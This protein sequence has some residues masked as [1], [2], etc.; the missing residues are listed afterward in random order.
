MNTNTTSGD[1]YIFS[2]N[3]FASVAKNAWDVLIPAIKPKKI[4]E[5]GSYEGASASYLI[6]NCS[7]F[8]EIEIHC[9][10][11]WEGGEEH[12]NGSVNMGSV[13]IRFLH[14]TQLALANQKDRQDKFEVNLITHK[15]YSSTCLSK[16]I[17][18]TNGNYFDFIYIDGSHQAPDVLSDAILSFHLLKVGGVI[19]FDDYLWGIGGDPLHCPKPAIDAFLNIYFQ[20]MN[21]M[22]TSIN[23]NIATY[24]PLYQLF[25]KKISQ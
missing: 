8:S 20:K 21:I 6:E 14:N 2:N 19:V 11:T 18:T 10:D 5:I 13:E 17:N 4:L 25:T 23:G 7:K 22:S 16:L 24:L 15:G 12:K 1:S 9:I 3:W